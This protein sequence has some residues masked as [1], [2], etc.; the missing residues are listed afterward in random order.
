MPNKQISAQFRSRWDRA[1]NAGLPRRQFLT[2]LAT[3]GAAGLAACAP[4]PTSELPTTTSVPTAIA[5]PPTA[6]GYSIFHE[7]MVDMTW[8]EVEKA[9]KAGAII[10]LPIAVIEEHGPHIGLGAD[11]Y[12][13]YLFCRLTR[14]ELESRGIRTLI[15]PPFYWGINTATGRFPGSFTVRKETL[16]AILYDIIA[17]LQSWGFT[18]VFGINLHA[19]H[20]H[21]VTVLEAIQEAQSGTGI[22][23]YCVLDDSAASRFGLT[24]NEPYVIVQNSPPLPKYTGIHADAFETG[25]MAAYFPEQVDV[26]LAKTLKP[27]SGF[28]PSGYWGSPARFDAEE[29]KRFIE[30]YSEMTAD[31]IET[32]LE[33]RNES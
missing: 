10:L 31:S 5:T 13:A 16:K 17:S 14:R 24:G 27:T 3:G 21:T 12:F 29:A 6:G 15:A 25:A 11:T 33:G 22:G 32:I 20:D 2:L 26:E 28:F 9:I 18:H 19:D 4:G 1:Q 7:T 23:A 30:A 8:P